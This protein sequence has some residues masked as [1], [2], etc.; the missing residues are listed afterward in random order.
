MQGQNFIV[1]LLDMT[2]IQTI[3]TATTLSILKSIKADS[4]YIT[5]PLA[6][7]DKLPV[8]KIDRAF[9]IPSDEHRKLILHIHSDGSTIP[10]SSCQ[11]YLDILIAK[12]GAHVANYY[13]YQLINEDFSISKGLAHNL[14]HGQVYSLD[15]FTIKNVSP[16]YI[17]IKSLASTKG[18]N[19]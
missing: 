17:H 6:E 18:V 4:S 12:S 1:L 2:D 11:T 9:L 14:G 16:F 3:I 8:S 19:Q 13:I 10:D 7:E 15:P 5:L